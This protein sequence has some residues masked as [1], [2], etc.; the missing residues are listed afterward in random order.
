M[1][2]RMEMNM[3]CGSVIPEDVIWSYIVVCAWSRGG[4]VGSVTN[5]SPQFARVLLRLVHY[6]LKYAYQSNVNNP[7]YAKHLQ[8]TVCMIKD[9]ESEKEKQ[10]G[11]TW[12]D[13]LKRTDRWS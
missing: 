4:G 8:T 5:I 3:W 9:V 1:V 13:I 7:G 2:I 6:N 10:Y 12:Q 11:Y